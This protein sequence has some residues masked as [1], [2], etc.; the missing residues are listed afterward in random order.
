MGYCPGGKSLERIDNDGNYEPA[1]CKWATR[2]E[3]M[4]NMSRNRKVTVGNQTKTI[5]EWARERG[6][7]RFLI[8]DR[9]DVGMDPVTAI[10][11][12]PQK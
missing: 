10:M 6:V 12:V 11:G 5:S 8:R 9:L 3:Q 4:S 7:S 2:R 1:N